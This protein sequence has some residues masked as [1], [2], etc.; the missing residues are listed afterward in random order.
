MNTPVKILHI[1]PDFK[2]TYFIKHPGGIIR[3]L[4]SLQQ[5][6]Q[7]LKTDEFDLILSEPDNKAIMKPQTNS[8]TMDNK[9][10]VLIVDDNPILR[11]GLKS[12]LSHS[13]TFDIVGEA[14][15]GLEAINSVEKFHP[16]LVLMDLSMPRMDGIAATEEIK[17]QWP[18]TK[19]LV[20]TIYKSPE[21]RA[22]AL[23]AG[24]DGYVSKDSSRIELIQN[25]QDILQGKQGIQ[26][27]IVEEAPH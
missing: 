12:V 3:S 7:L 23:N 18:D 17:K 1:D 4:I 24:A 9:I 25:I 27:N 10:R 14:A 11:E 15:D 21:Y 19:I 20:F 8:S 6:I 5:A 16:D 2:V 22:A 26:T 13:P